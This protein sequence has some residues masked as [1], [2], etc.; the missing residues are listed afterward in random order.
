MKKQS[1]YTVTLGFTASDAKL[2]NQ[3]WKEKQSSLPTIESAVFKL[4]LDGIRTQLDAKKKENQ[5][6]FQARKNRKATQ[7][8]VKPGAAA[9]AKET[10]NSSAVA[11]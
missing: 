6:K 5:Q 4:A 1:S 2:L 10:A 9:E 8:E 7:S 3:I 11:E